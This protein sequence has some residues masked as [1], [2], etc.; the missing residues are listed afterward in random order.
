VKH[1]VSL[2]LLNPK[3]VGKTAKLESLRGILPQGSVRAQNRKKVTA[4]KETQPPVL[5]NSNDLISAQLTVSLFEYFH[6]FLDSLKAKAGAVFSNKPRSPS[7]RNLVS[8]LILFDA[9]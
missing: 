6:V 5:C 3:T 8:D 9:I 4:Y 7:S 2:Q 1:F